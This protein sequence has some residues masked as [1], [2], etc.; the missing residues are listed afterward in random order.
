MG[1]RTR[2]LLI[3]ALG[4]LFFFHLAT[5]LLPVGEETVA[6]TVG[7]WPTTV[8]AGVAGF[9]L[10]YASRRWAATGAGQEARV[11][12]ADGSAALRVGKVC[13]TRWA[14]YRFNE[15]TDVANTPSISVH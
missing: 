1:T 3:F 11:D 15:N 2:R 6:A 13:S 10:L 14:S 5:T 4:T 7:E 12:G 9:S 8:A